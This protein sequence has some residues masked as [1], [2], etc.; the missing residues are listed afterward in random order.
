[1]ET[2]STTKSTYVE[3]DLVDDGLDNM[4]II[5]Y[6]MWYTMFNM[7]NE[8]NGQFI[9]DMDLKFWYALLWNKKGIKSISSFW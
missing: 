9:V 3:G 1:M 4:V 2:L 6:E 8:V 5:K 7:L